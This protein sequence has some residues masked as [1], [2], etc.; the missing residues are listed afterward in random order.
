[1]LEHLLLYDALSIREAT[2][3]SKLKGSDTEILPAT[4]EPVDIPSSWHLRL[5]TRPL[6]FFFPAKLM[7]NSWL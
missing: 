2:T 4:W 6:L 5:P 3:A 7:E 1:M